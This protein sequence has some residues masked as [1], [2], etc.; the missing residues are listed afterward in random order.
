VHADGAFLDLD[1][2]D[3]HAGAQAGGEAATD[4]LA[5]GVGGQHDGRRGGGLDQRRQH[6]DDRG[7]QVARG[8]VR[9]GDVD[10]RGAGRLEPVDQR[11]GSAR[12]TDHD[13]RRLAQHTGGGD[14]FGADLLQRPICVLS[15][16]Q[17]FSHGLVQ[18]LD[19][20]RSVRGVGY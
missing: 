6:V 5:V 2:V 12:G 11:R 7:D 13:G 17:Y 18:P 16:H 8:V 15:E 10:L 4:L 1:H 14:Q 19:L 9:L 20:L 3:Q